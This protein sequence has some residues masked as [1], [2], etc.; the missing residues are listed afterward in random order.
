MSDLFQHS[1]VCDMNLD[2]ALF[3]RVDKRNSHIFVLGLVCYCLF[4]GV[5][6]NK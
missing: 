1:F 4:G 6:G 5:E 3:I 2:N